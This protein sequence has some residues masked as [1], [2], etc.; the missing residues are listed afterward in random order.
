MKF[1]G[2]CVLVLVVGSDFHSVRF[3]LADAAA[4]PPPPKPPS[5]ALAMGHAPFLCFISVN[6]LAKRSI[7]FKTKLFIILHSHI[8]AF[9]WF[10]FVRFSAIWRIE[11][12]LF[13]F[14]SVFACEEEHSYA[15][16]AFNCCVCGLFARL[17]GLG[18]GSGSLNLGLNLGLVYGLRNSQLEQIALRLLPCF[19]WLCNWPSSIKRWLF[20]LAGIRI[21][22]LSPLLEFVRLALYVRSTFN[23]HRRYEINK[24]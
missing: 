11:R 22:L 24:L 6:L 12:V 8:F 3:R 16:F 5:R 4:T 20:L 18:F 19:C 9:D 2:F 13:E 21:W 14:L 23:A 10:S 17:F 7:L 1:D 15:L